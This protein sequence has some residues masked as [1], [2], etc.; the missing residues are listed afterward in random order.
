MPL[1]HID[2]DL[3]NL[4]INKFPSKAAYL[5]AL[6]QS[7]I[8]PNELC[9]VEGDELALDF[10]V[11]YL[12]VSDATAAQSVNFSSPSK[13]GD[14][15]VEYVDAS[16]ANSGNLTLN[17]TSSNWFE[18]YIHVFSPAVDLEIFPN[19]ITDPN[20]HTGSNIVVVAPPQITIPM[21]HVGEIGVMMVDITG[22]TVPTTS[23]LYGKTTLACIT[24]TNDIE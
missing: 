8:G 18:N 19:T 15:L 2:T 17:I 23:I 11:S 1:S 20:G 14:A 12:N 7:L 24:Y 21:G 9:L 10:Q 16:S 3:T 6:A 5:A 4:K 13:R 22:I